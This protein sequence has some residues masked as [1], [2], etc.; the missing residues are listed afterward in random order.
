VVIAEQLLND[1]FADGVL[2]T[3]GWT[4]TESQCLLFNNMTRFT[5]LAGGERWGKSDCAAHY[6]GVK[7]MEYIATEVAAGR[8]PGGDEMWLVAA[9]Y[10]RTKAEFDYMADFFGK[11]GMLKFATT[12]VDPGRIEITTT[13]KGGQPFYIRTKT[14]NDYRTL[15]MTA[16]IGI[17]VC[18]ASQIDFEAYLRLQGRVAEK[19]GWLFLEGTFESSLGWYASLW[20]EWQPEH[21]WSTEDSRSWSM[22]SQLNTVVYPL[23]AEDPE[24]LR[25]KGQMSEDHFNERHMGVPA[26]PHGLVHPGFSIPTHVQKVSYLPGEDVYLAIDPGISAATQSAYAIEA[27]HIIDGQIRVFDEIYKQEMYEEDILRDILMKKPW[28]KD[29]KF[30]VIDRAGNQRAGAHPPSVEVWRKVVGISPMFRPKIIEIPAG[31]RRFDSFLAMDSIK[32]IP[33]IVFDSGCPG[34]L[35]ELGGA[36]N[37]F[38]GQTQVYSWNMSQAGDR[39]GDRPRDRFNHAVKALVYLMVHQFGFATAGTAR[40]KIKVSTRRRRRRDRITV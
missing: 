7:V 2:K 17:I 4:P 9:D 30:A 1:P 20:K 6:G 10:A 13:V 12:A 36:E 28:F 32:R 26:P 29:I 35:S 37:P 21:I 31:I 3:V 39:I 40:R 5:L 24:I 15:A 27:C 14:A 33:G 38:T 18:E 34:V 11:L 19:R 8:D 23:G 16:P 25:L 22:A